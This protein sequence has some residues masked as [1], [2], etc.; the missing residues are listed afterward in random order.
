M[1]DSDDS[2]GNL[3]D[4][5]S[6]RSV[7][8]GKKRHSSNDSKRSSTKPTPFRDQ[9]REQTQTR[10]SI[11]TVDLLDDSSQ[12]SVLSSHIGSVETNKSDGRLLE[13][14]VS[15]KSEPLITDSQL[16]EDV[17]DVPKMVGLMSELEKYDIHGICQP[18]LVA[19]NSLSHQYI[20]DACAGN[21]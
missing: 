11:E 15:H 2:S 14:P 10:H 21:Y 8:S 9:L 18:C 12:Q 1:D 13:S 16:S 7:C 5:S 6:K 19:L 17:S 20:E 3:S 4:V